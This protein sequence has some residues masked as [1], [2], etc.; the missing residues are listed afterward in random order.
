MEV[1]HSPAQWGVQLN[2]TRSNPVNQF[3]I[4]ES[5]RDGGSGRFRTLQ[6]AQTDFFNSYLLI[7]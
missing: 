5:N 6:P 7:S 4:W 2:G 3:L 1:R